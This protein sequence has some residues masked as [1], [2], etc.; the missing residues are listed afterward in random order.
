MKR[1]V[2]SGCAWAV[3][4][5]ASW[6]AASDAAASHPDILRNYRFIPSRS[7]VDVSGGFIGIQ[8]TFHVFDTFGLVT[9]Y[10]GGVPPPPTHIPFAEFVD[11]QA[12]LVS[13]NG[14]VWDLDDTL[15]L[16]G[17][18]GSFQDPGH[19]FFTGTD[20]QG[21]PFNLEATI[22]DR[23][24]HL[25]GASEPGCCDLYQYNLN[26]LAYLRPNAD[27][28]LDGAVD[29]SD[30]LVWRKALGQTGDSDADGNGDRI[31]DTAD[32]DL[33]RAHFGEAIDFSIFDTPAVSSAATPEPATILLFLVT[34]T[35]LPM[36]PTRQKS[37]G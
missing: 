29:A 13:D 32:Y 21:Q 20:N 17:L 34:A 7:T 4:V 31:V 33:W 16:T 35:L 30:F 27:F 6:V 15:N 36:R 10:D 18:D 22:R 8:E 28:N 3:V 37:R 2:V 24:I 12:R 23:L 9:G 5:L 14:F 19:L 11:V 26:A 1:F 25:V